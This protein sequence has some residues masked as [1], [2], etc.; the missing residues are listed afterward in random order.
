MKLPYKPRWFNAVYAHL[1]GYFWLP[2]PICGKKF[3]GHESSFTLMQGIGHGVGVCRNCKEEAEKRNQKMYDSP[4][5]K[6]ALSAHYS[7]AFK[8]MYK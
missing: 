4:E 3:G 2:C 1:F 5:Y 6:K 8:E 7:M